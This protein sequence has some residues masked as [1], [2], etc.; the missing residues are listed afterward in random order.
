MPGELYVRVLEIRTPETGSFVNK[1]II[2]AQISSAPDWERQRVVGTALRRC[3]ATWKF[4]ITHHD[5]E[6]FVL[7]LERR[8]IFSRN[9]ELAACSLPLNWFPVDRVVRDWFPMIET[10]TPLAPDGSSRT[11]VLLDVHL[12]SRKVKEFHASF[13]PLRVIA[14]WPRP[15]DEFTECAAP[16]QIFI[17]VNHPSEIAMHQGQRYDAPA[18]PP[19]VPVPVPVAY[20]PPPPPPPH[21]IDESVPPVYPPSGMFPPPNPVYAPP[22][23]V[24]YPSISSLSCVP[25]VEPGEFI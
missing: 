16:K 1:L 21:V 13:A 12:D 7:A 11:M 22:S 25:P 4:Q 18:A 9:D 24:D 10:G 2:A 23:V 14:T 15:C 20:A 5:N 17:V 19:P 6:Q 3:D 8:R